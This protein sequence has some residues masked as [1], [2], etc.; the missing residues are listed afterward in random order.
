VI[1]WLSLSDDIAP[2]LESPLV[3]TFH[4]LSDLLRFQSLQELIFIQGIRD[5]L[6]LTVFNGKQSL[7]DQ[8]Q[9]GYIT[10]QAFILLKTFP[11]ISNTDNV[12]SITDACNNPCNLNES[13]EPS[14]FFIF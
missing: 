14:L 13:Q 5:E 4:H 11:L 9:L 12:I 7:I 2:L 3:H 1:A 8:D 6:F 10:H